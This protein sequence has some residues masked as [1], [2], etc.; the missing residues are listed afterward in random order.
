MH[1]GPRI[2]ARVIQWRNGDA[3]MTTREHAE[4][5]DRGLPTH[6]ALKLT[7]MPWKALLHLWR[8]PCPTKDTLTAISPAFDS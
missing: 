8:E 2:F 1:D 3:R 4:N 7:C 6:L 5:D